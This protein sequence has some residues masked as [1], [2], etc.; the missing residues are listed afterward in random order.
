M[1]PL[2]TAVGDLGDSA[3]DLFKS[4]NDA[5]E[6]ARSTLA[7]SGADAGTYQRSLADITSHFE[8]LMR[9]T[10]RLIGRSDR[11]ER[12]MNTL[13]AQLQILARQLEYRATHDG[14][15]GVLNRSA[16]IDLSVQTLQKVGAVMI[17]LDIDHFKQVNDEFGHPAGDA[18]IQGI[19]GC[20]RRIVGDS[21]KIGRVGGEEFTV[22]IPAGEINEGLNL[23]EAMRE[24]IATHVFDS[25]VN[26]QIT[27][28]FGVSASAVGTR[29]DTAYSLADTAL[30]LAKRSGRNR[31]E[32]AGE[33]AL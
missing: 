10:R 15:T 26:R 12:E 31:V 2:V 22:L 4:E 29:F 28:S 3:P 8:R 23:A 30:Y 17:V 1:T 6:R 14:L 19:V 25:P 16:V 27:A 18:V 9:E 5:L 13:N 21:G 24:A 7:L 11:A 33:E 20:L 32:L